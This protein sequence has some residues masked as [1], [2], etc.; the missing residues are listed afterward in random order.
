[1]NRGQSSKDA[2]KGHLTSEEQRRVWGARLLALPLVFQT[3]N[4]QPFG[5]HGPP[6]GD[7][8]FRHT[9]PLQ[10]PLHEQIL[11]L[12]S[13]H[14]YLINKYSLSALSLST[15]SLKQSPHQVL[16]APCLHP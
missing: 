5:L 9:A 11:L 1:M 4:C 16:G 15:T 2:A 7:C 8:C 10:D 3:S 12:A 14:S 6:V 13:S